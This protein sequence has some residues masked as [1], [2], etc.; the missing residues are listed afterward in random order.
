MRGT[1][2][3]HPNNSETNSVTPI[4]F[5]K[6][7]VVLDVYR[8]TKLEE[9]YFRKL[10]VIRRTKCQLPVLVGPEVVTRRP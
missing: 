5:H 8:T 2:K 3:L 6:T 7:I 10:K 4:F 1:G 9:N